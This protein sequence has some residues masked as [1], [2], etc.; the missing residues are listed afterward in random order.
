MK[1]MALA[2]LA[3]LMLAKGASAQTPPLLSTCEGP[4]NP[5]AC[6]AVRG[7]RAEGWKA[8]SRAEVFAQHGMVTTSQ[9][10]AAQAG[11]QILKQGGNAIDAAVAT[12]AVLSVVEP[13]NVGPGGD[14]FVLVYSAKDHKLYA[15]N[16]SGMAPTGATP[17]RFAALGYR[18]DPANWGP[19][20][21]MPLGGILPV[22]VPGSVWG[23][24]AVLSRFGTMTLRQVLQPAVD[25][26]EQGFPVS[27]R[28]AHDWVLPKA[29]PLTHCCTALDPDSVATWYIGGKPPVAGEIFRNPGLARTL[30]LLQAQ[31]PDAFYKGEI[32]RAIVAKS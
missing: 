12:A 22:T 11:L 3:A 23:W 2:A 1:L 27:Q 21:G 4:S 9:P 25:Y 20:S 5:P 16:A 28:I 29:L 31:G 14:L 26:A 30:R 32:A 10:L 15:L 18:G 8:Q 7:D 17:E 19:G 24:N 6:T 13:M